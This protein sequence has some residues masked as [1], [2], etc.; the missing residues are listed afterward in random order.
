MSDQL[1]ERCPKCGAELYEMS[2]G[3]L[4]LGDWCG[5]IGHISSPACYCEPELDFVDPE[6][7]AEVY[8]HRDM[9]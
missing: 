3:M 1:Q 6:T 4:C 9:Q 7:G 8:V 5:Y 2:F